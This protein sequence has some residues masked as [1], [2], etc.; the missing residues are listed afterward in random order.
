MGQAPESYANDGW[1]RKQENVIISN[2]AHFW[3]I[4]KFA[5]KSIH[6]FLS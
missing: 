5:S 2:L 3:H 1:S 6:T 4:L